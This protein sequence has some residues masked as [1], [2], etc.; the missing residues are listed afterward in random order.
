MDISD[1]ACDFA[2]RLGKEVMKQQPQQEEQSLLFVRSDVLFFGE[3]ARSENSP[4]LNAVKESHDEDS[5]IR[6]R[7]GKELKEKGADV[8][9]AS[10]GV[11]CWISD[12]KKYVQSVKSILAPGL[13]F[14]FTYFPPP[15]PSNPFS[16]SLQLL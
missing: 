16:F 13:L 12:L 2:K 7:V 14:S 11:I 6:E 8:V 1:V 9:Y 3:T 5:E 4:L 10:Y 15:L